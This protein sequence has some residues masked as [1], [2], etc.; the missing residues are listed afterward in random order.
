MS[1]YLLRRILLSVPTLLLLAALTFL[2]LRALP[3]D[4]AQARALGAGSARIDRAT[5]ENLSRQFGLDRPPLDQLIDWT[6]RCL[7]FDFG[8]SFADGAPVG[9]KVGRALLASAVLNGT[10]L[11]ILLLFSVGAGVCLAARGG[12]RLDAWGGRALALAGSVPVAWGALLLQRLLAVDLPLFPL[13][14]S[15][16]AGGGGLLPR[17]EYLCL[18]AIAIAYRGAALYTLLVR[19]AVA[20]A[21][22]SDHVKLARARGVPA[23]ILY[24]RH[25][26]RSAALPLIGRAAAFAPEVLAGNVLVESIFGWPGAGRLLVDALLAR[27]YAV[28]MALVWTGSVLTLAA[29]LAGDLLTA[30]IDPRLKQDGARPVSG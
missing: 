4:A 3:G 27:D 18:P 22:R 23:R 26:L 2:L 15:A 11:A 20:Q 30:S 28:L 21:L 17:P 7:R 24:L 10:A 12:T 9:R 6:G 14:G 25:T 16:P 29:L 13:L 5:L 8:S 1:G 19:Q